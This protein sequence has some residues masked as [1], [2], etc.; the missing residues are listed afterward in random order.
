MFSFYFL[1]I[2]INILLFLLA[3]SSFI[4]YTNI[5]RKNTFYNPLLIIY[6]PL[7]RPMA[8]PSV[9]YFG[10]CWKTLCILAQDNGGCLPV[11]ENSYC[12]NPKRACT[13]GSFVYVCCTPAHDRRPP[14]RRITN[15]T[16]KTGMIIG[17]K[18]LTNPLIIENISRTTMTTARISSNFFHH[19]SSPNTCIPG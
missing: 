19:V 14:N 15:I 18:N 9:F 4:Y 5:R 6:T 17:A 12:Y 8:P 2:F 10:N 3:F 13:S 7:K 1:S 16:I 11:P